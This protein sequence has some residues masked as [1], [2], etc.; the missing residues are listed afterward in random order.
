MLLGLSGVSR[1]HFSLIDILACA[2]WA[3]ALGALAS[4]IGLAIL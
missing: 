4:G 1:L 3:T 2:F